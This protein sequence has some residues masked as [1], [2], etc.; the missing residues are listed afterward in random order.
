MTDAERA[1]LDKA[2]EQARERLEQIGEP[3]PEPAD[4]KRKTQRQ[5]YCPDC[6]TDAA[7]AAWTRL[8]EAS[9]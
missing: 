8:M 4:G 3:A 6:A 2:A 7:E 9:R 5:G 1:A